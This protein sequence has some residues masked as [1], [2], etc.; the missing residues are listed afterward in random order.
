MSRSISWLA[1]A[2]LA[3]SMAFDVPAQE[4]RVERLAPETI[5]IT[6]LDRELQWASPDPRDLSMV[7]IFPRIMMEALFAQGGT[8]DS[9]AAVVLD[10]FDPYL[11]IG[12]VRGHYD[13][14]GAPRFESEDAVRNSVRVLDSNGTPHRPI[15]HPDAR[16]RDALWAIQQTHAA[17]LGELGVHTTF[18][19]FPAKRDD[20]EPV[21]PIDRR[22]KLTVELA[23]LGPLP[24]QQVV[25]RL[26]LA[27]VLRN[28]ICPRCGE[29]FNG[30]WR[31]CPWDGSA[32]QSWREETKP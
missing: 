9:G 21:F 29:A 17:G 10:V 8:P 31:F 12:V 16:A 32:L 5:D 1:G 2:F 30:A 18:C 14:T 7:W 4:L 24:A 27:S 6:L 22:A 25:W 3:C 19:L 20:G 23:A 28:R 13:E 11:I 15:S 26:P